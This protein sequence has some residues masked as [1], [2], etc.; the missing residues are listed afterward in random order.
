M[1]SKS[2]ILLQF[3]RDLQDL[4]ARFEAEIEAI[5]SARLRK[6]RSLA[7]S[8]ALVEVADAKTA[9]AVA[10]R[11]AD[12]ARASA[13]RDQAIAVATQK[14]RAALEASEKAWR[15][16]ES[17]AER[18]R[19]DARREE[20]RRHEGKLTEI[21]AILPM[22]KQAS[23]RETENDRHEQALARIQEDFDTASAR[24]REDY[25]AA[26][27]VALA[28]ELRATELA[29]DAEHEGLAAADRECEQTLANVRAGLHDGLLKL[30]ATKEL[31]E[32]FEQQLRDTRG[33]W[34]AEKAALRAA[35]KKHYD[36]A[37]ALQA[38]LRPPARGLHGGSR[39]RPRKARP[40][41][42]SRA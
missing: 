32:G 11:G 37:P 8:R 20:S 39:A 30:A 1:P 13:A 34:Q 6:L 42:R 23:P 38:R 33:R 35:F 4:N 5:E 2:Q 19:E 17:E 7:A 40:G 24:A 12:R 14:R 31:E 36:E 27:G 15:K 29:N 3:Q 26:N 25:Q 10:E 28:D 41:Q 21:G 18:A 16:A 22:Y 9:E